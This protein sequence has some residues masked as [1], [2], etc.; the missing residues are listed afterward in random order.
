M[1]KVIYYFD[2]IKLRIFKSGK[3]YW[4]NGDV[5][6]GDFKEGKKH[7]QGK[8]FYLFIKLKIFFK[9]NVKHG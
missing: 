8:F 1:E 4:W 9:R 5:Y 6:G 7:G 3:F 2:K